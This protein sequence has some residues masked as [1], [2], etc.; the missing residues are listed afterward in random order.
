M[1]R[2]FNNPLEISLRTHKSGS[3]IKSRGT[4]NTGLDGVGVSASDGGGFFRD[5]E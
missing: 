5:I 1:M 2:P 3:T 4:I